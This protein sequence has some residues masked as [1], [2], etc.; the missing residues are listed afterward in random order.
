MI[1]ACVAE[2]LPKAT[3]PLLVCMASPASLTLAI[4]MLPPAL[5]RLH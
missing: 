5:S 1:C 4:F 2:M 3:L